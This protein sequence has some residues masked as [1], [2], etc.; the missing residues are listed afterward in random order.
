MLD[1]EHDGSFKQESV[2]RYH[3]RDVARF[4]AEVERV[5]LILGSATPGLESWQRA[6]AGSD[7]LISMPQRILDRRLP[8]VVVLDL[9]HEFGHRGAA[10]GHRSPTAPGDAQ[11]AGATGANHPAAE[12][13]RLFHAHSVSRLW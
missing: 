2:P 10:G 13:T 9:R 8:D 6:V 1:E 5:P 3:A 7:Q 12:P 4:R 11:C